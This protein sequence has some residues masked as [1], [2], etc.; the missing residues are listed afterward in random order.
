MLYLQNWKENGNGNGILY[1]Y[2]CNLIYILWN[3]IYMDKMERN[4]NNIIILSDK[5]DYYIS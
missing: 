1:I 2:V 3:K 4:N 5:R